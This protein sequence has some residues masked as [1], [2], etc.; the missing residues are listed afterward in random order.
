MKELRRPLSGEASRKGDFDPNLAKAE[1][2]KRIDALQQDIR[3][4]QQPE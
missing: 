3:R 1:A 4:L 2:S